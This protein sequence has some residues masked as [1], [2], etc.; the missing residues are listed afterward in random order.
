MF[1]PTYT[2]SSRK[3]NLSLPLGLQATDAAVQL[4]APGV[5][6]HESLVDA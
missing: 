2:H 4:H 5:N 1:R 3:A 6:F